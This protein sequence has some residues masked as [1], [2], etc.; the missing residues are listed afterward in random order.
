MQQIFKTFV[1]IFISHISFVTYLKSEHILDGMHK[2]SHVS[3]DTFK[4]YT[5]AYFILSNQQQLT[6]K[7][8]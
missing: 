1:Q 8:T 6:Y 3:N 4:T 5:I 2:W 7:L